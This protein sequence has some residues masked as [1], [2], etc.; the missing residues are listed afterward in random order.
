MGIKNRQK[1]GQAS[2]KD[3][4]FCVDLACINIC[5][6]G[7]ERTLREYAAS[8]MGKPRPASRHS[9]CPVSSGQLSRL[10]HRATVWRQALGR[11]FPASAFGEGDE[12]E[13]Q[14]NRVRSSAGNPVQ[15]DSSANGCRACCC[16]GHSGIGARRTE[17]DRQCNIRPDRLRQDRHRC[18]QQH[19]GL[20]GLMLLGPG[21]G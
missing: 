10:S 5:I 11:R 6:H 13:H 2:R 4:I 12:N 8:T 1:S 16:A 7:S 9:P 15:S 21:H 3:R 18:I 20:T 19:C 17:P 14:R